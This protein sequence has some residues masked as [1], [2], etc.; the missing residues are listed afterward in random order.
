MSMSMTK[1]MLGRRDRFCGN[2]LLYEYLSTKRAP[3]FLNRSLARALRAHQHLVSQEIFLED[4]PGP[5]HDSRAK[6]RPPSWDDLDDMVAIE[7]AHGSFNLEVHSIR[8]HNAQPAARSSDQSARARKSRA[9]LRVPSSIRASFYPEGSQV[10]RAKSAETA[11]LKAD[12]RS[13][14]GNVLV[15]MDPIVVTPQ[16]LMSS[17]RRTMAG[18]GFFMELRMTF[19]SVEEAREFYEYM[20]VKDTVGTPLQLV[21]VYDNIMQCPVGVTV[22]QVRDHAKQ[23]VFDLEVCMYWANTAAVS[24]LERSNRKLRSREKQIRSYLTPPLNTDRQPSFLVKFFYGSKVVEKSGLV[25]PH[26]GCRVRR[27][28]DIKDLR[29]HLDSLHDH[30]KYTATKEMVDDQGVQHWRFDCEI[31]DHRTDQRA[32]GHA[33]EPFDNHVN[34]PIQPFNVNKHL[35][36]DT[37]F[38][39]IATQRHSSRYMVS[40]GKLTSTALAQMP[41]RRKP[42]DEVQARP[43]RPKKHYIVPEAPRGIVLFRSATK[44]PLEAGQVISESDDDLDL[45]WM[46]LRKKAEVDREAISGPAKRFQAMFDEYMQDEDLHADI[47]ASDAIVRFARERG[48]WIYQED[49]LEELNAKLAELSEDNIIS[50]DVHVACLDVVRST[51]AGSL[52]TDDA[53]QQLTK[54]QVHSSEAALHTSEP[55]VPTRTKAI[56]DRIENGK[57]RSTATGHLTPPTADNSDGDLETQHTTLDPGP[58]M[59]PPKPIPSAE[60]AYDECYCGEDAMT[61]HCTSAVIVCS[62]MVRCKQ[63]FPLSTPPPQDNTPYSPRTTLGLHT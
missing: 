59:Q 26:D 42:P 62:Q 23:V 35:E 20:G 51:Q 8:V 11:V 29:M 6:W 43:A 12:H 60:P 14:N 3:V 15:D 17:S 44:Q 18:T 63:L 56:K 52:A 7:A 9:L 22:I 39:Q 34:A 55:T 54:L 21:T 57:A 37:E 25:C 49:L 5:D 50:K 1:S 13:V 36:G 10:C 46:Q 2:I 24:I 4:Q 45:E 38:H 27:L 48:P 40:K 32:S 28:A 41:L 19:T 30:F 16:N 33:D 47:H 58:T 31:A 61:A 53:L